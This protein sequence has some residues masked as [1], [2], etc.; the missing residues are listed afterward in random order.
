MVFPMSLIYLKWRW[1]IDDGRMKAAKQSVFMRG[2]LLSFSNIIITIIE[3]MQDHHHHH[4]QEHHHHQHGPF[5]MTWHGS[6]QGVSRGRFGNGGRLMTS[7]ED[8]R[9][10]RLSSQC[11][12]QLLRC[13]THV[14][15]TTC[16]CSC[17][18][19]HLILQRTFTVL[20]L[21]LL[22]CSAWFY[23]RIIE[24]VWAPVLMSWKAAQYMSST[25]TVE[26]SIWAPLRG[27]WRWQKG[28]SLYKDSIRGQNWM[29]SCLPRAVYTTRYITRIQ[30][31]TRQ[32]LCSWF[33]G[34][35]QPPNA[36]HCKIIFIFKVIVFSQ[37]SKCTYNVVL[38]VVPL[39]AEFFR[40]FC[41]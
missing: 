6:L 31:N 33:R 5:I 29:S 24:L 19:T 8:E 36:T 1:W 14:L 39:E 11:N 15:K 41:W 10:E 26:Q 4:H 27:A 34:K 13:D 37:I 9:L 20:Y 21:T 2:W 12:A 40:P 17:G 18:S 25:D 3:S 32:V 7:H 23:I 28:A 22:Y 38:E 30:C 16:L 35:A